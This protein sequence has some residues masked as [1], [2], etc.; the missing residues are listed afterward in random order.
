M[1]EKISINPEATNDERYKYM[2]SVELVNQLV[3]EGM[4]FRD[5]YKEVGK[6]IQEGS[7]EVPEKLHHTHEGSI[8]KLC[9]EEISMRFGHVMQY[10]TAESLKTRQT[11]NRLLKT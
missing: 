8:G 2:Y 10:F 11:E 9:N 1:L 6:R 4:P 7:F 3:L 5:A